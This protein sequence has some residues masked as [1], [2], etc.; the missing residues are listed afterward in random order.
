MRE[1][2]ILLLLS[3]PGSSLLIRLCNNNKLSL[4][5]R[6]K[7]QLPIRLDKSLTEWS[8]GRN[9]VAKLIELILTRSFGNNIQKPCVPAWNSTEPSN[10]AKYLSNVP[11]LLWVSNQWHAVD[12]YKSCNVY[13]GILEMHSAICAYASRQGA[14]Q[15]CWSA[16][17]P[18]NAMCPGLDILEAS[19]PEVLENTTPIK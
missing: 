18:L 19:P 9:P 16:S 13:L 2:F 4:F 7:F 6:S 8:W 10:F 1:R 3:K 14:V 11:F 17:R 15:H 5:I 12:E